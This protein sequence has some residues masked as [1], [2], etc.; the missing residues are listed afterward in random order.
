MFEPFNRMKFSQFS[1][2]VDQMR[3]GV[4]YFVEQR[5][6]KSVCVM[7]QDTDFGRDVLAGAVLQTQGCSMLFI[8]APPGSSIASGKQRS[9]VECLTR[10]LPGYRPI[11]VHL[12]SFAVENLSH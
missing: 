7:Y 5:G 8:D 6:K 11:C 10:C 1:S 4:K 9:R 2:Y 12:R 3:A